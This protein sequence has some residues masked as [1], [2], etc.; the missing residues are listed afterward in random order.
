MEGP[1]TVQ[2][3]QWDKCNTQLNK[4]VSFT[5][6]WVGI[7]DLPLNWWNKE[8]LWKIGE[9]CGGL[10]LIDKRPQ[11]MENLFSPQVYVKGNNSG[12]IPSEIDLI[13]MNERVSIRLK[14]L[15]KLQPD[16]I[17]GKW[18]QPEL[19]VFDRC[20][21]SFNG[22]DE[23]EVNEVQVELC[24]TEKEKAMGNTNEESKVRGKK[25]NG[26]AETYGSKMMVPAQQSENMNWKDISSV[27]VE[28]IFATLKEGLGAWRTS[29]TRLPK[30]VRM[31]PNFLVKGVIRRGNV[32][33]WSFQRANESPKTPILLFD[34]DEEESAKETDIDQTD[35]FL[36]DIKGLGL[37]VVGDEIGEDTDEEEYETNSESIVEEDSVV[38]VRGLFEESDSLDELHCEPNPKRQPCIDFPGPYQSKI[39]P[40]GSFFNFDPGTQTDS[41][42]FPLTIDCFHTF[43]NNCL[44]EKGTGPR[45]NFENVDITNP[46]CNYQNVLI[47][48][49]NCR[50]KSNET[51][52]FHCTKNAIN[53]IIEGAQKSRKAIGKDNADKVSTL[54]NE[55]N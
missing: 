30:L 44:V 45:N 3:Q 13:R 24:Y 53:K 5:G 28:R 11:S 8:V 35:R 18:L 17:K 19:G 1:Y 12:F 16:K 9:V 21:I 10:K 32:M 51:P 33:E 29:D 14:A 55:M 42:S 2:L 49:C 31:G 40:V 43:S 37:T 39:T 46:G 26:I 27:S 48:Q 54:L 50:L 38:A 20:I 6:G 15:S 52:H 7:L 4:K 41:A 22:E 36:E 23:D 25:T 47:K 34:N